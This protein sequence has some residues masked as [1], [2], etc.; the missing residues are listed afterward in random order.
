MFMLMMLFGS[1]HRAHASTEGLTKYMS[2][3]VAGLSDAEGT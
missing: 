2:V 3:S 1:A